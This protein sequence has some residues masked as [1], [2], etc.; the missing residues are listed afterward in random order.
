[1]SLICWSIWKIDRQYNEDVLAAHI[2]EDMKLC[3]LAKLGGVQVVF[4][5]G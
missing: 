2:V 3:D 5:P 1:V 4:D